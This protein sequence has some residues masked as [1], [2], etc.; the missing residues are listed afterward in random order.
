[1]ASVFKRGRWVD[2]KGRKC[3]KDAPGAR[4]VESRY[5]TV[6]YY[7]NG[8]PKLTKGYT[9]KGASEQLGAKLERAKARGEEGLI[10]PYKDHRHRPIAQHVTDYIADLEAMGRDDKYRNN[11]RLR[12][13][14]LIAACGWKVLGDISADSF[15]RWRETVGE[16][17]AKLPGVKIGPRTKNLY[18]E[19]VRA[20]GNWCVKRKRWASNPMIGVAKVDETADVRRPRRALTPEQ[21]GDLLAVVPEQYRPVYRFIL[22]TGLRR[23]EV[24]DLVWGDFRLNSPS[25]FLQLRAKATKAK[26]ADALPLR[27]DLAVELRKLRGDAEDGDKVFAAVP[28][29]DEHRRF[30]ASA[31]IPYEDE[32]GRRADVHALRHTYGTMLAE[33]G[34]MPQVAMDLMRHTEM[35]LTM[36]NYNHLR[37]YNL[38]E[39]VERLP[40]PAADGRTAAQATG[41]DGRAVAEGTKGGGSAGRSERRSGPSAGR[42]GGQAV[43]GEAD[44]GRDVSEAVVNEGLRRSLAGKT[45]KAEGGI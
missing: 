11:A 16:T 40:L 45:K 9:D 44:A 12:L 22:A 32:G 38:A 43:T 4:Y 34:V 2:E 15:C 10:D 33:A 26:R 35:R 14:K 27:A 39:A 25:P 8:R 5:W 7:V 42:G 29:M 24:E 37:A 36:K 17:C 30:L 28:S 19:A 6:Q 21:V 20:F 18:L 41:T 13:G 3:A 31:G 23:Q 1:M